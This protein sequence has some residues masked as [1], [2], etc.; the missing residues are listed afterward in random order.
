MQEA[1]VRYEQSEEMFKQEKKETMD[2]QQQGS[3]QLT[4]VESD[5]N[6]ANSRVKELRDELQKKQN[7]VLKLEAEKVG[8]SVSFISFKISPDTIN[9]IFNFLILY[10]YL[11]DFTTCSELVNIS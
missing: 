5:L 3:W 1:L 11:A 10:F 7:Q 9:M 8:H 6:S 2:R 4:Q